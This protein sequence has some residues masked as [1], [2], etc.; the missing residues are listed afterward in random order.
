MQATRR[1]RIG[2]HV[3]RR[4]IR[5]GAESRF[6]ASEEVYSTSTTPKNQRLYASSV[7]LEGGDG[8]QIAY[9][10]VHAPDPKARTTTAVVVDSGSA[11]PAAATERDKPARMSN[12]V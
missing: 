5:V 7:D 8:S 6:L 10:T 12:A 1:R 4:V 11:D 9:L 3:V 2:R